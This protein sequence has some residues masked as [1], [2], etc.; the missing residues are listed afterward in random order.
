MRRAEWRN[1]TRRGRHPHLK[2]LHLRLVRRSANSLFHCHGSIVLSM[3]L[4]LS[5]AKHIHDS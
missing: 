4:Y 1:Y 2:R 5:G 3:A